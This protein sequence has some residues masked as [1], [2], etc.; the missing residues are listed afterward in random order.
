MTTDGPGLLST[1]NRGR[2]LA[3]IDAYDATGSFYDQVFAE[4]GQRIRDADEAGILDLAALI[5]WKRS[6][7]GSWVKDL[8]STPEREVRAI[9]REAF[10]VS[11]DASVLGTLAALP[12]FKSEGPIAT[13][14]MAARDPHDW[15]V[16]DVRATNALRSVGRPIG[17]KRGKTLRYLAEVRRLR[18]DLARE[19]PGMSAR[20]VD[21]GLWWLDKFNPEVPEIQR[22]EQG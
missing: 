3:A 12:G 13:A 9:T 16:L 5:L 11:G 18:D 21:K 15:G 7:Q 20:E 1:E 17:N 2:V 22:N 4:I 10:A 19:R 6:G 14:L 8:L